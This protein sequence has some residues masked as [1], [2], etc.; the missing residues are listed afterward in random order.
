MATQNK[1]NQATELLQQEL[2]T[3]QTELNARLQLLAVAKTVNPQEFQQKL[4]AVA[5][6]QKD[7]YYLDQALVALL[8]EY[9]DY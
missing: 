9:Y 1:T 2:N 4:E 3:K 7:I 8:G 5:N 6:V